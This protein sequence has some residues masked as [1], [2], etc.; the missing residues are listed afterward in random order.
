MA[1]VSRAMAFARTARTLSG[2]APNRTTSR[3]RRKRTGRRSISIRTS[4]GYAGRAAEPAGRAARARAGR[5][6]KNR[7]VD[8]AGRP[9]NAAAI[10]TWHRRMRAAMTVTYTAA[11]DRD[12]QRPGA[13]RIAS[14]C[15]S[16]DAATSCVAMLAIAL[17]MR[18]AIERLR[19]A[20]AAPRPA[21]ARQPEHRRR[22]ESA[23]RGDGDACFRM[24]S[25]RRAGCASGCFSF[26]ARRT[27]ERRARCRMSAPS[28]RSSRP[29]DFAKLKPV[30]SVRTATSSA[31]RSC[32][33]RASI[34]WPFR[35]PCWSG[36]CAASGPIPSCSRSRICS[37]RSGSRSSS[38]A[39]I[40]CA[41]A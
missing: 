12:A 7:I 22:R 19:A 29:A 10:S 18:D 28:H 21:R 20:P 41:T 34:F 11:A 39:P 31:G 35:R 8:P 40:R 30:F 1:I 26:S 17:A 5:A 24:R 32:C 14:I 27:P 4:L 15:R 33:S 16:L 9:R 6:A 2:L 3:D 38:A 36:G 37:R 23:R 13:D 25:D